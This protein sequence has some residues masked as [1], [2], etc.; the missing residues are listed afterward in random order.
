MVCIPQRF[1]DSLKSLSL[2]E[3]F[4]EFLFY[5]LVLES[6]LVDRLIRSTL[7]IYDDATRIFERCEAEA[8]WYKVVDTILSFEFEP[9]A[10][11]GIRSGSNFDRFIAS[12]TYVSQ[13]DAEILY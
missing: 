13:N 1:K 8:S 7:S 10:P 12:N 6:A 2:Q 11:D 3:H 4:E 9:V 5:E